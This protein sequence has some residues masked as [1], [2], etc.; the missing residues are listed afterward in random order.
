MTNDEELSN[1]IAKAITEA[2]FLMLENTEIFTNEKDEVT[3]E[4]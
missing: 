1:L 4:L 3:C 2:V